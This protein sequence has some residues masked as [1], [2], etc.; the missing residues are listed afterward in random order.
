MSLPLASRVGELLRV[1]P[2]HPGGQSCRAGGAGA[3]GATDPGG[4]QPQSDAVQHLPVN[5]SLQLSSAFSCTLWDFNGAKC[6]VFLKPMQMLT[7]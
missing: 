3:A 2:K 5:A 1:Q 4:D 6:S 7:F